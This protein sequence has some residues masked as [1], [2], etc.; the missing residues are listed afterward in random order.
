M[1][2]TYDYRISNGSTQAAGDGTISVSI[3]FNNL[4]GSGSHFLT[5]A[6][7]GDLIIVSP[8]QIVGVVG[9]VINDTSLTLN[10]NSNILVSGAAYA[11]DPMK[12]IETIT[13][14]F[15]FAP[16]SVPK[17]WYQSVDLGD[18]T[19]RG[20]GAP[21]TT[22]QFGFVTQAFRDAMRAYCPAPN[23][24]FNVTIRTRGLDSADAYQTCAATMI[25]PDDENREAT[26]RVPF[27]ILFRGMIVL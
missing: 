19:K 3:G 22:W 14:V 10:L 5:Q 4:T 26:R 24:A 9:L 20:L 18:G 15:P 17:L 27:S 2:P 8:G 13:P 12:N 21:L 1:T 7:V 11:I 25:W 6:H 23:S 16:K